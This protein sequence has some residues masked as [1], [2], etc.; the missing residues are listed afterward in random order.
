[1]ETLLNRYR[2][3]TILLLVI[4]A[5]LVLIAVQVRNDQDVRMFRVWTVTAVTPLAKVLETARGGASGVFGNYILMHDA[6][7]DNRRLQA[8]VDRLKMENRFLKAEVSTA[9]RA[10]ALIAFQQH[11]PSKTLAARVIAAGAGVNSKVVFID[12]GSVAGVERGMAVVTPD[13]IVGKVIAAYPTASEVML[14]TDPEFAA[15]VVSQKNQVV[16]TLKGQGQSNCKVDY[17]PSEQK[18]EV[19]EVFYTSGDD[20]IFPKGF[21]VG[22]VRSV[23]PSSPYQEILVEPA[24]LARGVEAV[25]IL[26]EGVHQAIPEAPPANASVYLGTSPPK[27]GGEQ[28]APPEGAA[29]TDADK[30][31]QKYRQIGAAENHK[32]GEGA[33]GTKPPDFNIKLPPPGTAPAGDAAKPANGQ[34]P[35]KPASTPATAN[36]PA[37]PQPQDQ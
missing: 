12:R 29:G 8:E 5:Q 19:G 1:M 7:E 37:K 4:F 23:R 33:P 24:G 22:V 25:L 32:F 28:G 20:R 9:D 31:L 18:V 13:G 6:R 34:L 27:P 35:A 26:L 2:N 10:K 16:G 30:L 36:P 15:G 3:I 14:I 21:P 17:V 11:T